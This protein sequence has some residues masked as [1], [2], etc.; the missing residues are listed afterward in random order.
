MSD[1]LRST[2]MKGAR[3]IDLTGADVTLTVD[4]E[5]AI[6][7]RYHFEIRNGDIEFRPPSPKAEI[8][9]GIGAH[10]NLLAN[11]MILRIPRRPA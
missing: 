7:N 1:D 6:G 11:V 3:E 5:T 2:P 8:P 4:C 10:E 9:R